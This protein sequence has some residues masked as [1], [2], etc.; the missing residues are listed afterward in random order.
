M[1]LIDLWPGTSF[2]KIPT[3]KGRQIGYSSKGVYMER[4]IMLILR[5]EFAAVSQCRGLQIRAIEAVKSFMTS[6]RSSGS[7]G[8]SRPRGRWRVFWPNPFLFRRQMKL[9]HPF[10]SCYPKIP[11]LFLLVALMLEGHRA[12]I[13]PTASWSSESCFVKQSITKWLEQTKRMKKR[14]GPK[15][16]RWPLLSGSWQTSSERGAPGWS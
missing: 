3:A 16:S 2:D 10:K 8:T 5:S 15:N 13:S 12:L 6:P 9:L 14:K 11:A 4:G 7:Y 1:S